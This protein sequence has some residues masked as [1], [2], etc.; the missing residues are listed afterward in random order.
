[1]IS[2]CLK[3]N[4]VSAL[5]SIEHYLDNTTFSGIYYSQKKF[6]YFNNIIIHYKGNNNNKFYKVF[7]DILSNYIVNYCEKNFVQQQL[8]FDFF[9]FSQQEKKSIQDSTIKSLNLE[10]NT[11]K[12]FSILQ[13]SIIKYFS[14]N[15][16]CNLDGFINFRL[17]NYK[18]FINLVLETV[19]NDYILQKEYSEYVNLLQD[20][21]NMQV[22]QSES[23]HLVYSADKKM[24]LDDSKNVIANTSNPQIYLS[25]ISFSSNDF[26]LNSLLSLLPKKLYIHLNSEEDNFIKFIK[27]IF[28]DKFIICE[29]YQTYNHYLSE[30]KRKM[31]QDI[32]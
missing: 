26:I 18:S 23:V 13:D 24:L 19:I 9:Y 27:L 21:I 4:N 22:P 15:S 6:K 10:D 16:S 31:N 12:K 17:Y 32:C 28:R 29:D 14:N 25:D 7:S 2:I 11:E 5:N 30:I 8:A 1:M 20:Y 3:S